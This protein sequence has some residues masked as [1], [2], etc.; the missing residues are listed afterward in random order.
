MNSF[1]RLAAGALLGAS[2][3]ASA[4][5]QASMQSDDPSAPRTRS[6]V[7]AALNDW[8]AAGYNPAAIYYPDNAQAAG[9]SVAQ[10]RDGSVAP[11]Q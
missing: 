1:Y 3:V 2:C 4:F 8:F 5:A 6:Q 9:R 11:V 7:V 10:R